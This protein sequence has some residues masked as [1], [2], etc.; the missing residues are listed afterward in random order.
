MVGPTKLDRFISSFK[1]EAEL[2]L[3]VVSLLEKMPNTTNVRLTHGTQ[4]HGKDIVFDSIVA[5]GQRELV[6]CVVKNEKITGSADSDQGAR[7]VYTQADQA[8]DTPIARVGDGQEESVARVFIISPYECPPATV[9]SIKGKLQTRRGVVRFLCGRELLETF[10]EHY[11]EFLVFHSPLYATYI[12][13]IEAGLN[14]DPA[15]TNIL[16]RHGFVTGSKALTAHYV[17]P[18]FSRELRHHVARF[19]LPD[20]NVLLSSLRF[21]DAQGIRKSLD[22][23]G[24]LIAAITT[25]DESGLSLAK[26]FKDLSLAV[27][28]AWNESYEAHAVRKDI[29]SDERKKKFANIHL[30]NAQVLNSTAAELVGR[31][32]DVIRTFEDTLRSANE[33][34]DA[35]KAGIG[36]LLEAGSMLDYCQVE[37]VSARVP[38]AL[39][40]EAIPARTIKLEERFLESTKA[41]VLITG[42]AGFGK[43]SFCKWQTLHDLRRFRDNECDVIP[44]YIPLHRHAQGEI[45]NFETTFLKAPELI[46]L[47]RARTKH[48]ESRRFRLYLDGLDEVPSIQRQQQLLELALNGKKADS[49]LSI[50]VTAREH[51][52]GQHLRHFVRIHVCE[53]DE[54]QIAQ[55]AGKWFDQD[56]H[57]IEEFFTQLAKVPNL[58][59]LMSV[60][61]L[62]TLILGV[63]RST[64]TLPESRVRLYEM[65]VSLLAGGWD[66]AKGIQRETR[67]GPSPK[68]IVLTKL[69]AILHINRRR[70]CNQIDFKNAVSAT[71]PGLDN[72]WELL[73]EETLQDG[74]LISVGANYAFAHLSFQEFLA[75]KD[76]FQP[77][78]QKAGRVFRN[79]L[80]GDDWWKEVAL[81]YI[82]MSSDPKDLEHF[83]RDCAHQVLSKTAD[84]SAANRL[85]FLLE[86]LMSYF[87]GAKPNFN[88]N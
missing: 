84:R 85:G 65:F 79:Y 15:V 54:H 77:S 37:C 48:A 86:M 30:A 9:N 63:Y 31:A 62:A 24:L 51:V 69:A 10:E 73:L 66:A 3:A 60:P 18:T 43:T 82:A 4:E 78:G 52:F 22:D 7:A 49:T 68:Q 27:R 12:G 6:A 14:S 76:L 87:R 53:F 47:W 44:V 8:L 36:S 16:F 70:D 35:R 28:N 40:P 41:D 13:E 20:N 34:V 81:F 11:P 61:L 56:Q 1:N 83:M 25:P 74:L 45:A 67:F 64:K 57:M 23:I 19:Y 88:L 2:R 72:E 75:A 80:S 38:L 58:K 39:A 26:E 50:I 55:L 17:R 21:D 59:P 46:E 42:P 32:H 29:T 71:L 33:C 5:F